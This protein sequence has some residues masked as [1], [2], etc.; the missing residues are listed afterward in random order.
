MVDVLIA[1]GGIA[2]SSLAILLGRQGL[3][4][5]L[6]ERGQFP[7]EKPCGEGLMPAGVAVLKRLGLA[8]AVGGVPFYGVR[9]H[10]GQHTA[11]GRFPFLPGLP[12]FGRG[13]RRRHLDQVLFHAASRTPGVTA[14]CGVSVD[15]PLLE[16]GRVNGFVV[17]GQP[18][19]ARLTV[20]ADGVRSQMR[21]LLGLDVPVVRKRFAVRTHLRLTPGR[22][23]P[24]WVDVFVSRG[25]ELYVTPLPH[26]EVLVAVLANNGALHEPLEHAFHRWRCSEPVLSSLLEG[27]EQM[28]PL[29]CTAPLASRARS[30]VAPGIV[31]LGDA[32]GFPDPI[33]GGGITQALMTAELLGKFVKRYFRGPEDWLWDFERERRRMLA[34]YRLLTQMVLWLADHPVVAERLIG[35]RIS[36]LWANT[37]NKPDLSAYTLSTDC[38]VSKDRFSARAMPGVATQSSKN[39]AAIRLQFCR[40]SEYMGPP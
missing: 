8:D 21:Q 3:E 1:G 24:P 37:E 30:G 17:E 28:T 14:H 9:Y 35:A 2:G 16:H 20:A 15:G 26:R 13:Q 27:A 34:D 18:R 5:E 12:V 36:W 38:C 19:R 39:P 33:T 6:F 32:A 31:L 29:L 7:K 23:Q 25:H 40:D 11:E 10:F 4:V 22:E